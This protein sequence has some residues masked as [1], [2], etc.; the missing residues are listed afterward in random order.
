MS[1]S[2]LALPSITTE[3]LS[4]RALRLSDAPVFRQ[5]TDEPAITGAIDFLP[6][7]FTLSDAQKLIKGNG[8]GRDCFWGVWLRESAALIGTV[9]THLR[10]VDELEIGYWFASAVHGCG[11]GAEAAGAVVQAVNAA[12]P[13][14]LIVAECRPQNEASWRLLERIGFQ[15]DGTVGSRSGRKRL[16]FVRKILI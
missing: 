4:L 14:R 10:S 12:F 15:A 6:T 8:D 3:R 2:L 11:I 16:I 5:M 1:L 7:P 13:D 9:G